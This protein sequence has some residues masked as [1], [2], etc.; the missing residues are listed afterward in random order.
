[1]KTEEYKKLVSDVLLFHI[2]PSE[3]C[4]TI[5]PDHTSPPAVTVCLAT[6]PKGSGGYYMGTSWYSPEEV[7]PWNRKRGNAIALGRADNIRTQSLVRPSLYGFNTSRSEDLR[8]FVLRWVST[9]YEIA[10][11]LINGAVQVVHAERPDLDVDKDSTVRAIYHKAI[12][13]VTGDLTNN[14]G[15]ESKA[16]AVLT[17]HIPDNHTGAGVMRDFILSQFPMTG[18][19]FNNRVTVV[20]QMYASVLP[21]LSNRSIKDG[22]SNPKDEG[23]EQAVQI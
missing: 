18:S 4:M 8:D 10:T 16:Y 9:A 1:M 17:K 15:A 22:G 12:H 6:A 20:R 11:E 13:R 23:S 14:Y 19:W 3:L 21:T 2:M 5:Y 7:A